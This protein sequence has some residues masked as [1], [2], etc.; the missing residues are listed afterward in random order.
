MAHHTKPP[1]PTKLDRT[2]KELE[3]ALSD[4]DSLTETGAETKT[5]SATHA[6]TRQGR[7]SMSDERD[8]QFRERTKKLLQ[9]LRAQLAELNE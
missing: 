5:S 9:E 6:G 2:L 1:A 8:K 7:D 3:T 4:W